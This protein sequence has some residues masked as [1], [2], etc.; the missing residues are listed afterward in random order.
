MQKYLENHGP[1][2]S[3]TRQARPKFN[4]GLG[5]TLGD[6]PNPWQLGVSP[7]KPKPMPLSLNREGPTDCAQCLNLR[8]GWGLGASKSILICYPNIWNITTYFGI[9]SQLLLFHDVTQC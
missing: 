4:S 5:A 1:N 6:S 9:V 8:S 7:L 2:P 3:P